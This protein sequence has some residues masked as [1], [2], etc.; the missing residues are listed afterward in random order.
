MLTCVIDLLNK[1]V[2]IP[3]LIFAVF[4]EVIKLKLT[5]HLL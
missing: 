2:E 5:K 4:N 3:N 1:P